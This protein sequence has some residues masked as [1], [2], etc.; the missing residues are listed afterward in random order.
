MKI[1]LKRRGKYKPF[2]KCMKR[3]KGKEDK[4]RGKRRQRCEAYV[5][6]NSIA[7]LKGHGP[8]F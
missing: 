8:R 2:E 3:K 1:V 4:G 6:A 5:T 7:S